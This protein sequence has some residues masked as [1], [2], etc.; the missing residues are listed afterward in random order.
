MKYEF[1]AEYTERDAVSSSTGDVEL[2]YESPLLQELNNNRFA[3]KF[4]EGD[5][6]RQRTFHPA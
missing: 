4:P 3:G 2:G 1:F 6:L 5:I